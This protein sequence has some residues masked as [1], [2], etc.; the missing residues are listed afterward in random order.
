[1]QRTGWKRAKSLSDD[2]TYILDEQVGYLL[3]KANQRHLGIFASGI[4]HLTPTQFAALAKLN[5]MGALSQNE[6]GRQ[7]AMDG[8]TIK[9]VID[10][11]RDRDLVRSKAD[12]NDRRRMLIELSEEGSAVVTD[13]LDAARRITRQTLAPLAPAERER[14]VE[15]L[16]KIT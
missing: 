16:Q 4:A 7:T 15:L 13:C 1:M 5:Q 14:L 3:R 10:R 6:L 11:L 9:G 2:G 8:A 12:P